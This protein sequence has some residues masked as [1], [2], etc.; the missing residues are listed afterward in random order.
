MN[1]EQFNQLQK[2][3]DYAN[4]EGLVPEGKQYTLFRNSEE[5]IEALRNNK[6]PGVMWDEECERKYLDMLLNNDNAT[7]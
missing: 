4:L 6:I 7:E 3:V 2:D 1:E 5:A